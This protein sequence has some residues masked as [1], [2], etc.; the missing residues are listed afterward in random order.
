[1]KTIWDISAQY[2]ADL[3]EN[4]VKEA[5][6]HN[7][8]AVG[9]LVLKAVTKPTKLGVDFTGS[10]E[11]LKVHSNDYRCVHITENGKKTFH[12]SMLK[13]YYG[14]RAMAQRAAL[15]DKNMHVVVA[16]SA[17]MKMAVTYG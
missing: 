3:V 6:K 11:V 2:Q 9:D 13:P 4:K 1:M 10:W 5:G 8:Y 17:I 16:I 15:L 14:T 12:V 7:Q